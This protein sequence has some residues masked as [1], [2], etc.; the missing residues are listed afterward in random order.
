MLVKK[1]HP[2]LLVSG[3]DSNHLATSPPPSLHHRINSSAKSGTESWNVTEANFLSFESGAENFKD[4]HDVIILLLTGSFKD[5]HDDVIN[6]L[7]TE[8]YFKVL[9]SSILF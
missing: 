3:P 5:F 4:F 8:D 2:E 1:T 7:Q 9:H 6:L